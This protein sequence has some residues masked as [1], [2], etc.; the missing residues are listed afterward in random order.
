MI[1]VADTSVLLNLAFLNLDGLLRDLFG[2]VLVPDAVAREFARMAASGGRFGG[3]TMPP[4]CK[5]CPAPRLPPAISLD[6][7]LDEGEAEALALAAE[8]HADAVL[9]DEIN[10]RSAAVRLGLTAIG[11]VGLLIIAKQRGIVVKIAP[12]LR[13]LIVEGSFRLSA[14]LVREALRKA[15]EMA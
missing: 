2:E 6:A 11:T 1:V 3:L 7:S 15:G 4:G 14:E 12:L 13:R 10:A 8:W 5:V 9:L